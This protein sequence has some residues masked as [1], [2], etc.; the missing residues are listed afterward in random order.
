MFEDSWMFENGYRGGQAGVEFTWRKLRRLRR[1]KLWA[2]AVGKWDSN[3][4]FT[5]ALLLSTRLVIWSAMVGNG[6]Q[7][8]NI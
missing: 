6:R 3:S 7:I 5:L 2:V 1:V 4:S 8:H